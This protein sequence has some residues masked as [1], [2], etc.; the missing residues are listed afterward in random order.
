MRILGIETSC[1]ETGIAIYDDEA[2]LLGHQLHS[3][4]DIHK[5]YGGVVP[6]LASRD[7]IRRC[8]PMIHDLLEATRTTPSQLDAIAFTE[9]PGLIGA[10]LV[11]ASI[12]RSLGYA[13]GI[14]SIGIHHME[15]HL[16]AAELTE[17]P[18]PY[19]MVAL[20]VSGG[21]TQLMASEKP[22]DYQLLGE[23][24]DDAAGE[25]F[26]KAAKM[27]GLGYPGGPEIARLAES[28]RSDR[29]SFPRPMTKKPGLDFSF[30]GLKT[31]TRLTIE[32][33]GTMTDQDK[34]D[35]ARAFQD[36][37]VE[38][39][40]IKCERAI[41]ETGHADLVMAGG[42]SAN[43]ELRRALKVFGEQ[44]HVNIHY[45]DL[46]FCTD[47][48]AMIAV[49]GLMRQKEWSRD[50]WR[51]DARARWPMTDLSPIEDPGAT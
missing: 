1:D 36:A 25:A 37:V 39:I 13:W 14:P 21:H 44:H 15:G 24:V 18:P 33:L 46:K 4:I 6:E 22:G 41:L 30:S 29:F 27:L 23:S 20:L 45:P 35:I 32:S 9:G 50:Q 42:V 12:A 47:N 40:V 34:A 7:H 3:Q 38:T 19:P 43:L 31:H 26:D 51:I 16:L 8:L 2:G 28:G 49:A 10:L 17:S 11:G 5:A 48:G